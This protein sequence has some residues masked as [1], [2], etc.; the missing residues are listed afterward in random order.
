EETPTRVLDTLTGKEITDYSQLNA[1][2][3]LE[4][5][6]FRLA[7]YEWGVTYT[8]M[9]EAAEATADSKYREYVARRFDFLSEVA[10]HFRK[11]YE[12]QCMVDA[13][14]RQ[15]TM[16]GALDDAAALCAAMVMYSMSFSGVDYKG[17]IDNY[18]Y[19]IV[20]KEHRLADGTF[21]RM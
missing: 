15:V 8:G 12:E 10:P 14:F 13:E 16:P 4:K 2:A 18:M 1:H 19:F 20:H 9:L 17:L 6:D 3:Q 5:G 7:S 11:L 21:A